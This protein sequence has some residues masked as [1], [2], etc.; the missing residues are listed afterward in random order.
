M[1]WGAHGNPFFRNLHGL[2][3]LSDDE[4]ALFQ[5]IMFSALIRAI[6]NDPKHALKALGVGEFMR[7]A[8]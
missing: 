8:G 4:F 3:L 7:K 6:T 5:G 1:G 2:A